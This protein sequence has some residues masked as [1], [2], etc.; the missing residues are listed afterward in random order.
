MTRFKVGD[1]V[2]I[3][4]N[5]PPMY[6]GEGSVCKVI[7]VRVCG[8]FVSYLLGRTGA[9]HDHYYAEHILEPASE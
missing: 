8:Q 2:K 6:A 7:D 3:R 4:V 5:N 9:R 1:C